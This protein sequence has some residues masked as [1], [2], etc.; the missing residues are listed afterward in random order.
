M[1][2]LAWL[3]GCLL[4]GH[5]HLATNIDLTIW[6]NSSLQ[7]HEHQY[8]IYI[9]DERLVSII[10]RECNKFPREP[11]TSPHLFLVYGLVCALC[12]D[13]LEMSVLSFSLWLGWVVGGT[14]V[15]D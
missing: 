5:A 6:K 7:V 3:V 14:N 10:F 11:C 12:F 2:Q 9:Y 1:M 15:H 4:L 13:K 8:I